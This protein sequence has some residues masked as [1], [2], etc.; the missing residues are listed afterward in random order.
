MD[1]WTVSR[2]LCV[3]QIAEGLARYVPESA[4]VRRTPP[5]ARPLAAS[6]LSS[7][8]S[9]P[10]FWQVLV[11]A[12][13]DR[14]VR[15]ELRHQ[16]QGGLRAEWKMEKTITVSH[17]VLVA[18]AL[19][20]HSNDARTVLYALPYAAATR[21]RWLSDSHPSRCRDSEPFAVGFT[22]FTLPRL[23]TVGCRIHIP[24]AAALGTVGCRIHMLRLQRHR[25]P[26]PPATGRASAPCSR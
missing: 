7:H 23:G 6:P 12:G 26:D 11:G 2:Q 17:L 25:C 9:Q 3:W 21:N 1:S 18:D 16:L 24:H 22:S 20:I 8:A 5:T 10:L 4:K 14:W 19:G 15:D 13:A